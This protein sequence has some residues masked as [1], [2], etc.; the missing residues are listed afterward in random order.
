MPKIPR[1]SNQSRFLLRRVNK[2][3]KRRKRSNGK[4]INSTLLYPRMPKIFSVDHAIVSILIRIIKST[5]GA[6]TIMGNWAKAIEM[7]SLLQ[8]RLPVSI[9]T[10]EITSFRSMEESTIVLPD[11][12]SDVLWFGVQMMRVKLV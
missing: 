4:A 11:H 8:N 2:S 1:K 7:K 10:K 12:Y 9:H 6:S 5:H 3:L